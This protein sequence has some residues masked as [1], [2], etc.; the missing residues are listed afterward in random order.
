MVQYIVHILSFVGVL[1]S[2]GLILNLS[3]LKELLIESAT[4][5][6]IESFYRYIVHL[7]MVNTRVCMVILYSNT[8]SVIT[9]QTL[10][11]QV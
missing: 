11:V 6:H 3:S 9:M 5:I 1:A 10:L 8:E 7:Y 4:K 2:K